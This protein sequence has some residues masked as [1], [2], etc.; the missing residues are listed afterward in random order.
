MTTIPMEMPIKYESACLRTVCCCMMRTQMTRMPLPEVLVVAASVPVMT[1]QNAKRM[2]MKPPN[3]LQ[4]NAATMATL[5]SA[6]AMAAIQT[7]TRAEM[8]NA[9]EASWVQITTAADE[10]WSLFG[11]LILLNSSQAEWAVR[12]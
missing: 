6:M 4:M 12:D 1:R 3:C 5:T 10:P 9:A 2:A 8:E 11:R 7:S